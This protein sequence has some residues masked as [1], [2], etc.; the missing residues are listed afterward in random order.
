MTIV[1][2]NQRP[3][4]ALIRSSSKKPLKSLS[5]MLPIFT[6]ESNEL[7]VELMDSFWSTKSTVSS[8]QLTDSLRLAPLI[9]C[10]Q[11]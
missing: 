8:T 10:G 3:A 7:H 6:Q 9:N 5:V 11:L 1:E 2:L 4:I